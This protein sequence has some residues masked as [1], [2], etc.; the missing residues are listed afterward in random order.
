[1]G[2]SS[3]TQR[4]QTCGSNPQS[5]SPLRNRRLH[6]SKHRYSKLS[7]ALHVPHQ[8]TT[9][10]SLPTLKAHHRNFLLRS[11]IDG[12]F[13]S[14]PQKQVGILEISPSHGKLSRRTTGATQSRFHS[15]CDHYAPAVFAE[16]QPSF[17]QACFRI[18][19]SVSAILESHPVCA[20][21]QQAVRFPPNYAR[22]EFCEMPR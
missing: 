6:K 22:S 12:D 18:K 21:N 7:P 10:Y 13:Q 16:T 14:Q 2:A 20:G 17:V 1:V 4:N 8:S 15:K 19:S 3:S 11:L 5:A 9:N